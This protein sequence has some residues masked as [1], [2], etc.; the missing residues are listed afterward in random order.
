MTV[1][2]QVACSPAR[3]G[4]AN[5]FHDYGKSSVEVMFSGEK[6]NDP[7]VEGVEVNPRM[8]WTRASVSSPGGP[9][10][11]AASALWAPRPLAP[12]GLAVSSVSSVFPMGRCSFFHVGS[13]FGFSIF[14][15]FLKGGKVRIPMVPAECERG[16]GDPGPGA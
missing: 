10:P 11:E 6:T 13:S 8:F 4:P 2:E 14:I 9:G 12:T 15:L 16:S 7:R 3:A 1:T 5:W